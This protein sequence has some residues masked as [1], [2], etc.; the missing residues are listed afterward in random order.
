MTP[1]RRAK[2]SRA[3]RASF[4]RRRGGSSIARRSFRRRSGGGGSFG[5]GGLM[6][7]FKSVLS[8]PLLMKAGGAV[9]S[10]LITGFILN[11]WGSTLPLASNKYG[12]MLYTLGIPVLGAYL[13]RKQSRDLAEGMVIG[14]LVMTINTLMQGFTALTAAPAVPAAVPA[15]VGSY[16]VAGELGSG[17]FGY[18]PQG[19]NDAHGLGGANVAFPG[20]AW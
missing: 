10:S 16:A 12:R 6:S 17:T 7:S 20:S 3:V 19:M 4:R 2:I 5:G 18:Y 14:G 1:A 8:K 15:A 13:I 11:K 9:G